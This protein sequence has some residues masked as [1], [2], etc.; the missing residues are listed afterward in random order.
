[1][2]LLKNA[3]EQHAAEMSSKTPKLIEKTM[4]VMYSRHPELEARYGAAGKL[5]CR[6]DV[7]F[8]YCTLTEAVAARDAGIFLKYVEW[9]KIVLVSRKVRTDDLTECLLIM[10]EVNRAELSKG[11][12]AAANKYIQA[13]LTKF[14]EM[15]TSIE[16]FI[17]AC[18]PMAGSAN[19]YLQALLSVD[20]DEARKL[21]RALRG[22][23]ARL[24]DIYRYIFEPVQREVG[25]LWQ[26]NH[27][28]VAQEHYC[29]A[30]TELIMS[31]L[32]RD[33]EHTE[34]KPHFF[35]GTCVAGAQHSIGIRML[36]ELLEAHGWKVYF[37]GA[38]TPTQSLVELIARFKID[39]L[40][41]SAATP[42]DLP[43]VRKLIQAVRN[44]G[45]AETKIMVGGR[46]FNDFPGLW[47]KVGA[48]TWARDAISGA[49][50]ARKL[51]ERKPKVTRKH[52]V[53]KASW[54]S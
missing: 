13:A 7:D 11:T 39:V 23:G 18:N 26:L 51:V 20:R 54:L 14:G 36:S 19:T 15:S 28:S 33:T 52:G 44:S 9:G 40:G 27:I 4:A 16:P 5:R 53:S 45:R 6:E 2:P 10:Q 41:I 17:D 35:L 48:D 3:A 30:S 8:H 25:R 46:V 22:R 21:V 38:N 47:K 24:Q 42:M 34:R 37:T 29:T 1:M 43:T 31:E 50:M 32:Q 12:A 49:K